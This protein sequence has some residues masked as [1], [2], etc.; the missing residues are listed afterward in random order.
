M[1]KNSWKFTIISKAFIKKVAARIFQF[2][3]DAYW[4]EK[5]EEYRK[6]YN[7]AIRFRFNGDGILF[8]GDGEII[9]G[10]SSY[11]GEYSTIQTVKGTKVVI[12]CNTSISHYV[13]I[14]TQNLIA[15]QDLSVSSEKR[16]LVTASVT[17]GN[18]CWIGARTFI[19]EGITIG[20]NSVIGA[21]SVV[22][23]DIPPDCVAGGVPAKIIYK[24]N[25][26]S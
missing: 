25:Y 7:I 26:N 1:L 17:I 13:M 22:T 15:S 11:I 10:N 18:N 21:N 2:F 8:C 20:D 4:S 23:K 6:K 5:Y 14:Y 16:K 3:K 24:K 19:R 9:C 12:G